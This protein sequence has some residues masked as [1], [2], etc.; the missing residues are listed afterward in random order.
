MAGCGDKDVPVVPAPVAGGPERTASPALPEQKPGPMHYEISN[1]GRAL[2][3]A[4]QKPD[5]SI[6]F[7][8]DANLPAPCFADAFE[9]KWG[10]FVQPQSVFLDIGG[11]TPDGTRW[12]GAE[13]I[14]R[15]TP[16][17]P[18]AVLS[19]FL[20]SDYGTEPR[21][22]RGELEDRSKP[23]P[24]TRFEVSAHRSR[25]DKPE[26]FTTLPVGV[27]NVGP[28]GAITLETACEGEYLAGRLAKHFAQDEVLVPFAEPSGKS[29]LLKSREPGDLRLSTE[30]FADLK[31]SYRR[32]E[33]E[34]FAAMMTLVDHRFGVNLDVKPEPELA[35][36]AL[37]R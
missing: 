1:E 6:A 30:K 14:K 32:G 25:G 12:H 27:F 2:G 37:G 18:Y 22:P 5:G 13:E 28:D 35:A 7:T 36:S 33:P 10:A 21:L 23:K 16:M 24:P 31:I 20:G 26:N 4:D 34:F 3:V 9:T 19:S 11:E 8:V 29:A 17:Y 15:G